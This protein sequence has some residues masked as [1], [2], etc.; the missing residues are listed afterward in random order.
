[1]RTAAP[2]VYA[3]A[4]LAALG[5]ERLPAAV[6]QMAAA[7]VTWIQVRAKEAGGELAHRLVDACCRRLRGSAVALWVDDRVDLAALLPV[8]GVHL[9]QADLPPAAARPL[10]AAGQLIGRSTHDLA[11]VAAAA[12]DPAVDVVAFGPIF[13]T[14]SKRDPDPVVG[15]E[16]LREARRLT[17]KPLVAIGGVD[18]SNL[19]V[20]LAAGADGAA[21]LSAVCGADPQAS[22][23]HLLQAAEDV[24]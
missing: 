15:V 7:G 21:V 22:C 19:R 14:R 6:E 5:A 23:R 3:I 10:L 24:R 17:D 11:Q 8:A 9:G 12:A 20:V 1:M 13:P 2:R 4:D 16:R 18:A